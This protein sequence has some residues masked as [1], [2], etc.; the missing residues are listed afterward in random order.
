MTDD[1]NRSIRRIAT[2][3]AGSIAVCISL[4]IPLGY[5]FISYQYLVGNVDA[6][7]EI[8]ARSVTAIIHAN[9]EMWRFEQVRLEEIL[10]RPAPRMMHA[11]WIIGSDGTIQEGPVR[12]LGGLPTQ[13]VE[14]L[15]LLPETQHVALHGGEIRYSWHWP[16]HRQA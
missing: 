1:N 8:N 9:S 6:Q 2:L 7:A 10:E 11:H 5:F 3:I 12:T 15:V 13:F 16:I 14:N 4:L